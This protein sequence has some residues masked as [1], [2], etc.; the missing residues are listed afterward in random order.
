MNYPQIPLPMNLPLLIA[1]P[2]P[3]AGKVIAQ[4]M[5]GDL[6]LPHQLDALS[7]AWKIKVWFDSKVFIKTTKHWVT[8]KDP[9]EANTTF[10]QQVYEQ[11]VI[12]RKKYVTGVE[13]DC[14]IFNRICFYNNALLYTVCRN[15]RKGYVLPLNIIKYEPVK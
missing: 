4:V 3:I 2:R 15:G 12:V 10:T 14:H 7:T 13:T 11:G 5:S 1:D 9:V 6:D 8:I